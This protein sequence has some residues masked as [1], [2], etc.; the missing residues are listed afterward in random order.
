MPQFQRQRFH[1]EITVRQLAHANHFSGVEDIIEHQKHYPDIRNEYFVARL[2]LLFGK[3]KMYDNARKLFDEMPQLNCPRSV[4]SFNALLEACLKSERY[5]KIGGLFNKLPQKLSIE[6]DLVSNNTAIKALY[7]EGSLDS[8][9]YF[10]DE[11][12]KHEIKPNIVT[13]TNEVSEAIQFF[14]EIVNKG[15]KPDTFSYNAMIKMYVAQRN[16]KEAKMWYEKM[17]QNGCLPDYATFT[18]LITLACDANNFDVALVGILTQRR[19]EKGKGKFVRSA[20]TLHEEKHGSGARNFVR[21]AEILQE[22]SMAQK[23]PRASADRDQRAEKSA[24]IDTQVPPPSGLD[25][26]LQPKQ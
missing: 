17:M 23:K 24:A 2:I 7:K 21:S 12:E 4:F 16:L 10:M 3:A 11:M 20:G 6:P 22:E 9:V 14:K 1:C 8:A 5:D 25:L 13:C 18:M 15:F 19:F 26:L